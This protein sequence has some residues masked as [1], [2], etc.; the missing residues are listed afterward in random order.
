MTKKDRIIHIVDFGL[1]KEYID[2]DNNKYIPYREHNSLTS[3]A[4]VLSVLNVFVVVRVNVFFGKTKVNNV[5][6]FVLFCF[7]MFCSLSYLYNFM[8]IYTK[9]E[10]VMAFAPFKYL[11]WFLTNLLYFITETSNPRIS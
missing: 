3:T 4:F 2:P 7:G 1:A 8:W 11:I 9:L 10:F 5:D 6:D